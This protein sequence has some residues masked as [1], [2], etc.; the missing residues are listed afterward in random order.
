MYFKKLNSDLTSPYQGFQWELGKKVVID[1]FDTS[2]FC[3]STRLYYLK[4]DQLLFC[5][6]KPIF[7]VEIGGQIK[8]FEDKNG[9][10]EMT[11]LREVT[12]EEIL[13]LIR[14]AHLDQKL[15]YKYSEA[16][17][18]INPLSCPPPKINNVIELLKSWASVRASVS[19]SVRASVSDSV[20]DSVWASVS[21]SVWASVSDSVSD[22]VWASVRASVSD[23]VSDSVRDSVRASIY[24]YISSLF[25]HIKEWKYFKDSNPFGSCIDLWKMGLIPSF[26]GTTWRLHGGPKAEILYEMTK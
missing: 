21:D 20:S 15:R 11:V 9:C 8:E 5:P 1:N 17:Y 3:C 19:A 16:L 2:S 4:L 14:E 13:K 23:S 6:A 7:E 22:S 12:K 25:P 24:A 18:P 10:S 26:D